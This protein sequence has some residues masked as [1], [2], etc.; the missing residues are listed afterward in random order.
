[1]QT[2]VLGVRVDAVTMNK[3]VEILEKFIAER[4]PRLVA[5]AN[6]E[7]IMATKSDSYL[8][9]I[10]EQADLIVPDGAGV[11]WAA[12]Y[13]GC[14]VP[15]R[16]AGYDLVQRLLAQAA[17]HGYRVYFFGGAEGV[18]DKA[19]QTAK[20][21]YPGLKLAGTRNGFFSEENELLII[22]EIRSSQPDILL[23]ALGV[24][25]QE[26]WLAT[27]LTELN[28][29]VSIGVGGTFDVMAGNMKRAPL[30]MQRFNLEWLFR[31]LM[32]PTRAL[33][34]LALPRFVLAVVGA[35][36]H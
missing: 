28:V 6:A 5:T 29:P 33:R 20:K 18:A 17:S 30:W 32:Q 2:R 24:P 36:K 22:E 34:M 3:A 31:L 1:V 14:K 27:H 15:E 26:K 11:V 35:K 4:I 19:Y 16:V 13:Q 10:L 9:Q 21:R 12:R 7:M 8:A 25:K 23:T